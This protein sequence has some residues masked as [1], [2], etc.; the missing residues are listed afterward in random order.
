MTERSTG[1]LPLSRGVLGCAVAAAMLALPA[2][3]ATAQENPPVPSVCGLAAGNTSAT[4]LFTA[5][6]AGL[7]VSARTEWPDNFD[8]AGNNPDPLNTA[9]HELFHG[10]GFTVNYNLFAAKLIPTPG[11]GA[12]GV[13]AGSRSY[14]NNGAANGILMVLTPAAQGT[15]ADPGATGAAP[16]PATGYNQNND[17]MQPNQVVGS[18]LNANDAAVLDNAFG[19][20]ASGIKINVVNVGGT[21]DAADMQIMNNAV[22]AVNT[23]YPVKAASPVFTWSV[24]EVPEPATWVMMALG[25]VFLLGTRF[26][27]RV[28]IGAPA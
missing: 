2:S 6:A 9:E 1:A 22:G 16:W 4:C 15:H 7:P 12:N 19:W 18:R 25:L 27:R 23:F 13:P 14:S 17:L 11:A 5:N 26:H 10:I 3:I 8:A 28:R 20:V 24:A 21:L